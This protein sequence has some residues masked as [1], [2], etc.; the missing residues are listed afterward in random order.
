[1]LVVKTKVVRITALLGLLVQAGGALAQTEP[2]Y[3]FHNVSGS[4]SEARIQ[5]VNQELPQT[6]IVAL[7]PDDYA[8]W[9]LGELE[10]P[11]DVIV[12][13]DNGTELV[14]NSGSVNQPATESSNL[15]ELQ[16]YPL[17]E[18]ERDAVTTRFYVKDVLANLDRIGVENTVKIYQNVYDMSRNEI[19]GFLNFI[20][21][22]DSEHTSVMNDARR[23]NCNAFNQNLE[24]FDQQV[25]VERMVIDEGNISFVTIEYFSGIMAKFEQVVPSDLLGDI[26]GFIEEY[27][28]ST[29][30]Y[31]VNSRQNMLKASGIE[32]LTF[33]SESCERI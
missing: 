30:S 14:N 25:A 10:L 8:A 4:N 16:Q 26:K 11:A 6:Q 7:S 33:Y 31:S 29:S 13:V 1:M 9:I 28:A 20:R 23:A 17:S 27:R 2:E 19:T 12:R 22:V 32:P 21:D 18:T 5:G 24:Q 3:S 15:A